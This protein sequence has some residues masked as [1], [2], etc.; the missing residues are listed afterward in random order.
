MK[1]YELIRGV[2]DLIEKIESQDQQETAEQYY[3]DETRRMNQIADLKS[4][5]ETAYANTPTTAYASID[6]VTKDAGGGTNAPKHPADIR[7]TAPSMYPDW[8]AQRGE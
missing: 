3:D 6:A 7:T 4:S 8:Q 1:A 2:L 5:E